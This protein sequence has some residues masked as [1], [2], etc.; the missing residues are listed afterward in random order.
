MRKF[1]AGRLRTAMQLAGVDQLTVASMTGVSSSNI[2]RYLSGDVIPGGN[3]IGAIAD[4]TKQ[5]PGYFFVD[6][7]EY[8]HSEAPANDQSA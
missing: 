6:D 5:D 8:M 1:N 2:S 3:A 4:A 7:D